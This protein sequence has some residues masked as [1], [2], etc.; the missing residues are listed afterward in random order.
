[1]YLQ[2]TTIFTTIFSTCISSFH[3]VAY[4]KNPFLKRNDKIHRS[5]T[6]NCRNKL[7]KTA[8]F[9]GKAHGMLSLSHALKVVHHFYNLDEFKARFSN[10]QHVASNKFNCKQQISNISLFLHFISLLIKSNFF[11]TQESVYFYLLTGFLQGV[12]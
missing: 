8:K 11:I 5:G 9:N 3:A 12:S 6:C 10:S 1:M 2:A 7:S 4:G